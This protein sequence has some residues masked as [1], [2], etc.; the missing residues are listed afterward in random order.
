MKKALTS[1]LKTCLSSILVPEACRAHLC[2]VVGQLLPFNL[3]KLQAQGTG[4][5]FTSRRESG[6]FSGS[7]D[8]GALNLLPHQSRSIVGWLLVSIFAGVVSSSSTLQTYCSWKRDCSLWPG[9]PNRTL[10]MQ[11]GCILFLPC[12]QWDVVKGKGE[13]TSLIRRNQQ[14]N[15]LNN[16]IKEWM[17]NTIYNTTWYSSQ[18]EISPGLLVTNLT[19]LI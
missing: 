12:Q 7:G 3:Q 11:G 1:I 19:K 16:W 6:C 18:G 10:C 14:L 5:P 2:R 4:P 17:S 13:S 9:A 8:H 15:T